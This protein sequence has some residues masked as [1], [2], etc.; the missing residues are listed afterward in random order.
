MPKVSQAKQREAAA[1][2]LEKQRLQEIH[3]TAT[4]E[5]RIRMEAAAAAFIS[6][7][8]TFSGL[9]GAEMS[10]QGFN[11]QKSF[12]TD[13]ALMHSELSEAL[14]ADRKA[15]MDDKLP[16]YEGRAVELADCVIRI[17]HAQDKHQLDSIGALVVMKSLYNLS[18]PFKHGKE[19]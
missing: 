17:L 16:A 2:E 15:L 4:H 11:A 19:Y 5:A 12:P 8:D 14:E 13:I 3:E 9:I 7:W 1:V 18:R 10:R 6:A